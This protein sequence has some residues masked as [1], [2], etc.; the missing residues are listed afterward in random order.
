ML[1]QNKPEEMYEQIFQ[2]T[3]DQQISVFQRFEENF[4]NIMEILEKMNDSNPINILLVH[5]FQWNVHK[6]DVHGFLMSGSL[7]NKASDFDQQIIN[8]THQSQIAKGICNFYLELEEHNRSLV[9]RK[10]KTS[11]SFSKI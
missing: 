7:L 3:L 6:E 8:Q 5:N 1:N 2:G 4:E 9:V 10:G 11:F